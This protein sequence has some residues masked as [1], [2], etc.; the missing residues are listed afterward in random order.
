ME[1]Y[2][3]TENISGANDGSVG[4][5]GEVV[6]ISIISFTYTIATIHDVTVSYYI[7]K[8]VTAPSC[9]FIYPFPLHIYNHLPAQ[10]MLMHIGTD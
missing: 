9:Q 6:N 5:R 3:D 4:K 7:S 8:T 10:N 2:F 1:D